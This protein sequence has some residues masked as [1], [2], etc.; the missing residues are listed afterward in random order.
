MQ[1]RVEKERNYGIDLLRIIAM[2]MVC[3]IHV[4]LFTFALDASLV[5]TG[6]EYFYHVGVW[7]ESVGFIGVNLYALITGYVC[8]NS[9]WRLSRYIE[10]WAQ[11]AYYSIGLLI[12]GLLLSYFDILSWNVGWRYVLKI[13]IKL[14]LGSTYWYFAAYSALFL[15]MP[16]MNRVL[17]NLG[18]REYILLLAGLLLLIPCANVVSS[19]VLYGSGY[20]FVCLAVLYIAGG[21]FKRFAPY[22]N[23]VLVGGLALLC[24]FQPL[25]CR[26]LHV[27][28]YL[29]YCS[30]VMVLYSCCLF[31][32][33]YR[34][35]IK[36]YIVCKSITQ[37]GA[38]SFG[39]YLIHVHPWSWKMLNTYVPLLNEYLDYPWWFSVLGGGVLYVICSL[40]D[41]VRS[42]LFGLCRV[43]RMSE[44]V[45]DVIQKAVEHL[46]RRFVPEK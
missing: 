23:P 18:K 15:I 9:T 13:L 37:L 6:K 29:S 39:V 17:Q 30:P 24:T 33:L 21:Y 41:W 4:N 7:T 11:V 3:M 25:L 36:K 2:F 27:P 46:L 14:P 26:M 44:L 43:K 20:N 22:A 31:M 8:L 5:G 16:F 19:S 40:L 32:L 35:R 34:V 45:A 1:A 10:L 38:L 28:D 42:M 12:L